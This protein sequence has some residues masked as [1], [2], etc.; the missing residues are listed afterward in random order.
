MEYGK[1]KPEM[2]DS[3]DFALPPDA[4]GNADI[5]KGKPA[6][7]PRVWVGC[8]KWGR[9]DWVG[10]LYPKGTKDAQFL[11]HYVQHFNSIELNATHY[12]VYPASTLGKWAAKAGDRDFLFCPKVPQLISHYSDLS[13]DAARRLTDQF[14]E[15]ISAFGPTLGPV[16]LQVSENYAPTRREK[17][18]TY[19][20]KWPADL[21][22]FLEVRHAQWF[23]DAGIRRE[24]TDVLRRTRVGWIITDASGRRDGL[25]MELTVP[26]AFIRYVGNGLHPTDYARVDDW[27]DRMDQ[28]LKSGLE[29][30]Y[31]FMHQHDER[32][33]PQLIDYVIQ[34]LNARC[35]LNLHRPGLLGGTGLGL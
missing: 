30:L 22:L 10:L 26:K 5:L 32:Y 11:D 24:L 16:F 33:S 4:P 20:E 31:F 15:G 18:F 1:V 7:R 21:P 8:A 27:V 25:H 35:G 6:P 23:A 34:Q 2:L 12:Q 14:L 19:L 17:L 13:G 28:W 29:E 3:I 9:K